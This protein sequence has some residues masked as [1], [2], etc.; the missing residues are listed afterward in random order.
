[1]DVQRERTKRSCR[2]EYLLLG[3]RVKIWIL[4]SSCVVVVGVDGDNY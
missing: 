4:E 1:M 3:H 2:W